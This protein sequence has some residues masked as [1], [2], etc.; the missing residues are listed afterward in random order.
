MKL[1]TFNVSHFS[2]KARWALD[3]AEIPYVEKVLLPGPHLALTRRLG[4]KTHVPLLCDGSVVVQGSSEI[5]DHVEKLA[6][7]SCLSL[8]EQSFEQRLDRDIGETIQTVYYAAFL[9]NRALVVN[10][11]TQRGP[12]WGRAFYAATFPRVKSAVVKMYRTA[13]AAFVETSRLN[14]LARLDEVDDI[15]EQQSYL[16]GERPSRLDFTLAALLAPAC[17][18]PEHVVPWPES[19]PPIAE[20]ESEL[21]QRRCHAHVRHLYREYRHP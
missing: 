18:P 10:L 12:F 6:G 3:R 16:G 5:L 1:Y 19:P 4:R 20:L 15:L 13:D 8:P 14:L 11:W 21:S 7:V 9:K 2:E 17:Q